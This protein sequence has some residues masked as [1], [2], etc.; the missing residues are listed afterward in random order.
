MLSWANKAHK[1]QAA[2]QVQMGHRRTMVEFSKAE[3]QAWLSESRLPDD[4]TLRVLRCLL[5][6]QSSCGVPSEVLRLLLLR[7]Y[8]SLPFGLLFAEGNSLAALVISADAV[9]VRRSPDVTA[10]P[11]ASSARGLSLRRSRSICLIMG[12][13][14]VRSPVPDAR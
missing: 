11:A 5:L 6:L 10:G 12:A 14:V 9:T 7:G 4:I 13:E 2:A 3:E 1:R 8:I